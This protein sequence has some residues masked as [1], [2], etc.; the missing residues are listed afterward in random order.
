MALAEFQ[1]KELANDWRV[2][3]KASMREEVNWPG[4]KVLFYEKYFPESTKDKILG[5]L[6]ALQQGNKTV[7]E[8]EAEFNRL[9][10]F[11]PDGIRDNERT[12]M[13]KFRDGMNLELQLDVRGCDV[14]I[15]STLVNKAKAMEE[16]RDKMK[17]K[18]RSLGR[19][20][21]GSFK[22]RKFEAGFGSGSSK[23]LTYEKS[24]T[25]DQGSSQG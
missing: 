6:L 18:D 2:A 10:K 3:E 9:V 22:E 24:P 14:T 4:F 12:K 20:C 19:R 23:K 17:A 21:F 15:L 11:T 8:Y 1:L 25:Q 7:A 13:Q 16:V 5:Q